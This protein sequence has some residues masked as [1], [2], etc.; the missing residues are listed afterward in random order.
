MRNNNNNNNFLG[1]RA[2]PQYCDQSEAES[3]SKTSLKNLDIGGPIQD[4]RKAARQK[5]VVTGPLI[6][7]VLVA[8][9]LYLIVGRNNGVMIRKAQRGDKAEN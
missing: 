4:M 5:V 6:S 9:L 7:T 8:T 2:A 3:H 1:D